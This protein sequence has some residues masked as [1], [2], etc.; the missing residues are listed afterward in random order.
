MDFGPPGCSVHGFFRQ[1][2][3]SGLP[4]PHILLFIVLEMKKFFNVALL[5]DV[6]LKS[7]TALPS[8]YFDSSWQKQTINSDSFFLI[9]V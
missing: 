2:Y 9:E 3:W 8:N 5:R 1:E 6:K 7:L 4:N